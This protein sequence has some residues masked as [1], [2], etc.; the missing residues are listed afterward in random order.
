MRIG[1]VLFDMQ[2]LG[3]LEEYAVTMAAT[4]RRMGHDVSFLS[5]AWVPPDNQYLKRLKRTPSNFGNCLN[6]SR[7]LLQTGRPRKQY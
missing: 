4:L 3:G 1:M 7:I 5:T 2:E 6:G